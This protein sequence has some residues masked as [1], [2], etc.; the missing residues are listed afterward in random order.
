M[1]DE[2]INIVQNLGSPKVLLAGDFL[3]DIYVYGDALRI[4]PEAPV[5]VLKVVSREYRPGG[6]A[7]VAADLAAL[8]A[9]TLCLGTVGKDV[10]A[11]T[12]RELLKNTGADISGLVEVADR[13]T[14]TKQRF[15]GLAQHI[16]PQQLLRVDE[17]KDETLSNQHYEKLLDLYKKKLSQADI[18]CLQDYNKGLFEKDFC[19]S[20]IKLA[21]SAGKK[22]LIDPA[23]KADFAKYRGASVITP[24]RLE[25]STASEI[26]IKTIDDAAK[27]AVILTEKLDIDTIVIT[28]DKEGSYLKTDSIEQHIP[29]IARKVY[30][31]S[32]AG[33]MV[34]AS[35]AA[36]L[37][38]G[39][40][41]K[42]AV[43]ICNVA[44]GIEVEKF[45]TATVS[46][47]EIVNE[48]ISRKQKSGS[49]IKSVDQLISQLKWHRG[50]KQKIVFTNGCFDVLHRGHIEFLSFCKKHGDIVVLGLNSDKSVKII[51]GPE[52]PINNQLDRAAVLSGLESVD[53]IVI[54]DEPD[55]LNIIKQV[56]PDVLVKGQDWAEKGVIGREFVESTGG[57]VVLAPLVEGKSSTNTIEKMKSLRKHSK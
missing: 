35:L 39:V 43:E 11:Q 1:Y 7:S 45:G 25:A 28:L 50:H 52:R 20:L 8:G 26:N 14:I 48:L 19:V 31:V 10:N 18:V 22:V 38:A 4:S 13:P 15:V 32:G 37:A 3:L 40:D 30:D 49:K 34:L 55:P 42:T 2:L 29:T 41:Y 47:E 53:Y 23:P 5:P 33:D 12:L 27:A 21:K 36:A 56:K 9:K 44:G 16:H 57:E 51:K 54:F 6:A 24:N 17:E 46:I